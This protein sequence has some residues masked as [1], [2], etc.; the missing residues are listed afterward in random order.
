MRPLKRRYIVVVVI[1]ISVISG[2]YL[3]W[4]A[5]GLNQRAK[6]FLAHKGIY[7][8]KVRLGLGVVHLEGLTFEPQSPISAFN[9]KDATVTYSL[10]GLLRG[11][12]NSALR[13]LSF[14]NPA[15]VLEVD[16][17]S[18]RVKDPKTLFLQLPPGRY[19]FN[20]GSIC[21]SGTP[22]KLR[23]AHR[24]NGWIS[25]ASE[26]NITLHLEGEL[27]SDKSNA[28]LD[29]SF[30][31][32]NG[33][34][35]FKL[36]AKGLDL[37]SEPFRTF[38]PQL[39][40]KS[41]K[42]DLSL[43]LQN[44]NQ[45]CGKVEV[46]DAAL[47]IPSAPFWEIK[48]LNLS[49]KVKPDTA[50]IERGEGRWN[51]CKFQID[52]QIVSFSSP[53]VS[54]RLGVSH[55]GVKDIAPLL[56]LK[57]KTLP[58]GN[59]S[60]SV[61]IEGPP[62]HLQLTGVF[63]QGIVLYNGERIRDLKFQFTKA[64]SALVVRDISGKV[65]GG[66]LRGR[67]RVGIQA[68]APP[69]EGEFHLTGVDFARIARLLNVEAIAGHGDLRI[70]L[71]GNLKSPQWHLWF[72]SRQLCLGGHNL[73]GQKG[74]LQ[75]GPQGVRIRSRWN[76][77]EFFAFS[78]QSF[79][80]SIWKINQDLLA[81][82]SSEEPLQGKINLT[83]RLSLIEPRGK[84]SLAGS[85]VDLSGRLS[86]EPEGDPEFQ[87]VLNSDNFPVGNTF[88]A[89]TLAAS[90]N[91][92]Q[93]ELRLTV[94]DKNSGQPLLEE[95][96]IL[97]GGFPSRLLHYY[98][99]VADE[100]TAEINGTIQLSGT[101]QN[102][103]VA[104]Q[105]TAHQGSINDLD[106]L[107]TEISLQW[108]KQGLEI[109]KFDLFHLSEQMLSMRGGWGK[110]NKMISAEA[111][112]ID[113]ASFLSLFSPR[114]EKLKGKLSYKFTLLEHET[115]P[116][117]DAHFLL[118]QAQVMNIPFD[119]IGGTLRGNPAE[120][121]K[122]DLQLVKKK[123]YQGTLQ[124]VVPLRSEK[125]M[126]VKLKLKGDVL[127]VLPY[128]TNQVSEGSGSGQVELQLGGRWKTPV[129]KAIEAS[130]NRGSL[131]PRFLSEEINRLKG[132]IRLTKGSN[133]LEIK[134][135]SGEMDGGR[136]F[137]E[138]QRRRKLDGEELQPFIIETLGVDLGIVALHT[139][140][141][142]IKLNI[143]GLIRPKEQGRFCCSHSK[144]EDILYI[145]GPA[146]S[147]QVKGLCYV[148]DVEFTFPR[149]KSKKSSSKEPLWELLES[150][151]WNLKVVAGRNVRYFRRQEYSITDIAEAELQ[152]DEGA[153]LEFKGSV[154]QRSF[155]IQGSLQSYQGNLT[156]LNTEFEVEEMGL[157]LN[158]QNDPM[159]LVWGS[160]KT[161]VYSDSTG[162]AT[163]IFLRFYAID[164]QTRQRK[165]KGRWGELRMELTSSD[166]DDNTTEKILV[167]LGYS[168]DNYN[169]GAAMLLTTGMERILLGTLI[170]PLE[171]EVQK[172]LRLD[173]FYLQPSLMSNLL[174]SSEL[175]LGEG[176]RLSYLAF[177]RGTEWT[178][179][180][181]FLG[182]W[183]LFYTGELKTD[184][185]D[186]YQRETLGIKHRFGIQY[187]TR[188]TNIRFEYNYDDILRRKDKQFSIR[189]YFSF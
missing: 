13:R 165:E 43:R 153:W 54:L 69:I 141:T 77:G 56:G 27:L 164:K 70:R 12:T 6:Q 170:R 159:P 152:I 30:N 26:E 181:Y 52:G 79:R 22:D 3:G 84:L 4:R 49:I 32:Q 162:A 125:E 156:Y 126:D 155:N 147:P 87:V 50:I 145:T 172:T 16:K 163:D 17:S 28:E 33:T 176:G 167:K 140:K 111:E 133:F 104:V 142:G 123:E 19:D 178:L 175:P 110:K 18:D 185:K 120:I 10:W 91:S 124:G 64:E 57:Q 83:G 89:L 177:L 45:V 23:L 94:I 7:A 44:G 157:E 93:A 31:P 29:G 51:G 143:P 154:T 65:G 63:D 160:A 21:L 86:Q 82:G 88:A 105:L 14:S 148:S 187:R 108:D 61:K 85:E 107:K 130:F 71:Q 174:T 118:S 119:E 62:K 113:A 34:Y 127:S 67:L 15:L 96:L 8:D 137:I 81:L 41:G 40:P 74:E 37:S 103:A 166:S 106:S 66:R 47:K 116:Q 115:S 129:I 179:G 39:S 171:R 90:A 99:T 144:G 55:L 114:G 122:V 131:V 68:V 136:F 80:R 150:I 95:N 102:P 134:G 24:I 132:E 58:T 182:N 25:S 180:E 72:D 186:E 188:A 73:C 109:E 139:G 48:K 38:C 184:K 146:Q 78:P 35:E 138:N 101:L 46:K 42:V 2:L 117:F 97:R 173:V 75:L 11:G 135:L 121:Q 168:L 76:R 5:L 161:T 158:T 60:L 53:S 36:T 151:N 92:D 59:G 169:Q 98:K 112:M 189:R 20:G 149:L 128:L 183:L 9:V 1:A 100:A